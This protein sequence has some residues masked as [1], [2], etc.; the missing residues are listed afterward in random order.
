M[1][2]KG[3]NHWCVLQS[4]GVQLNTSHNRTYELFIGHVM[5]EEERKHKQM[6]LRFDEFSMMGTD[7]LSTVKEV[8]SC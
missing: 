7:Y 5:G 4:F 3:G 8:E 6:V 2:K 1:I